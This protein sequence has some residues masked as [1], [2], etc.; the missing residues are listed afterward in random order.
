[1]PRSQLRRAVQTKPL[2]TRLGLQ[3]RLFAFVFDGFVYSQVWE[4]PAVDL[5]A[6]ELTA[7]SDVLTISSAGCNALNYLLASPRSV[8]A[9]DIN[10]SHIQLLQL[11]HAA[12]RFL[13]GHREFFDMFARSGSENAVPAYRRFIAPN[14]EQA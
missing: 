11:K 13:P 4:D 8:T 10:R 2:T 12:L 5:A 7:D 3:Q 14:A 1:M 6:L 9:V